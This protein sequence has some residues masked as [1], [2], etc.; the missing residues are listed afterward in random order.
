MEQTKTL[1]ALEPYLALTKSATSPRAAADLVTQATSNPNAFVFAELLQTPQIQALS[2]SAEYAAYLSLLQIFSYGTY[3]DYVQTASSG[4]SLPSLNEAQ[5][6]KLR[7][8]SMLTLAARGQSNLSYDV[9]QRELDLPDS[10][11]VEQLAI[12]VIYAHLLS[13]QLDPRNR[14][15]HVSSLSPLRDLAPDSVP[16]LKAGL[17]EWSGR[18]AASLGDLQAQITAYQSEAIRRAK[19]RAA[20]EATRTKLIEET[21]K[22]ELALN[23]GVHTR[24]QKNIIGSAVAHLRASGL[25]SGKRG[26][27]SLDGGLDS[28]EAM[29]V[30]EE[31]PEDA[32]SGSGGGVG[33]SGGLGKKP[34]SSR[35]KL[36]S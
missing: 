34:K 1:N 8:L 35:R 31:E 27:G 9:L 19:D 26:S 29:D 10:R 24:G 23:T 15:I 25:R 20:T 7:Q 30:D 12:S 18:I 32:D 22:S 14:T 21:R 11:A 6:L 28:D 3:A 13:A 33:G 5:T 2:Q 36:Q 4:T 16:A 17:D